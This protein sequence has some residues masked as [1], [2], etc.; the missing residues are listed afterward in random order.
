MTND[1]RKAAIQR[2]GYTEREAAVLCLAALHSGYF[3]RRQ[4]NAF[5]ECQRGGNAERLI[6][7]GVYQGH[8]RVYQ[9]ANRTQTSHVG[10]KPFFTAIGKKTTAIAVGVSSSR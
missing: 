9:S 6:E 7:Q 1:E 10:A 4:C 3:L 2:F 5:L 8:L